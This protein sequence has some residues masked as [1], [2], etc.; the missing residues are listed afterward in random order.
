MMHQAKLH[1]R[2]PM[3]CYGSRKNHEAIDVAVN[4][5]L[6]ADLLRQKQIHSAIAP[7]LMQN[8]VMIELPMRLVPFVHKHGMCPRMQSLPCF[9][10]FSK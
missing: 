3:E 9:I 6:V 4:R 5:R 10:P 1:E 2:I 8:L 7:P